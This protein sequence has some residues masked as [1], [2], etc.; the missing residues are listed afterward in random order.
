M[1]NPVNRVFRARPKLTA[2]L[3]RVPGVESL[4]L[5]HALTT[6]PSIFPEAG[7]PPEPGAEE[8]PQLL[9]PWCPEYRV[10]PSLVERCPAVHS[11][12]IE[13]HVTCDPV[14]RIKG[15]LCRHG[16]DPVLLH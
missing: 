2:P 4:L 1:L 8:A 6:T 3:D 13:Q 11:V 7:A 15:A 16:P 9:P 12:A 14:P 10:V 5:V